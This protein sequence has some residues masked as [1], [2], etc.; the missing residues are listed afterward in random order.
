MSAVVTRIF[1]PYTVWEDHLNGMYQKSCFMDEHSIVGDC[2]I[3]LS[4][5]EWLRESMEFVARIWT[6]A[7]EHN[8]SN[9]NRNRQ[10]WLGQA[11]CSYVF[12]APEYLTKL[13]WN[14]LDPF[15]QARA[16]AVADRV[17]KAWEDAHCGENP[18]E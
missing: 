17:I 6:Y 16:N 8:L 7:A 13:A 9:T 10:A 12:G 18:T 3:L 1:H 4:C 11:A 5:P 15:I 14:N 2:E